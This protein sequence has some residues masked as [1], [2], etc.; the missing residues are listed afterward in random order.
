YTQVGR[1]QLRGTQRYRALNQARSDWLQGEYFRNGT[2][3]ARKVVVVGMGPAGATVL[4]NVS[5]D[6][7]PR[8]GFTVVGMGLRSHFEHMANF[9]TG[10]EVIRFAVPASM[11]D[12]RA[13]HPETYRAMFPA[14]RR[15]YLPYGTV[16]AVV[17]RIPAAMGPGGGNQGGFGQHGGRGYRLRRVPPGADVGA[18]PPHGEPRGAAQGEAAPVSP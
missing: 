3:P 18:V 5:G 14:S 15:T 17:E 9:E 16:M 6:L 2:Q 1:E 10:Q 4:A 13:L 8:R 11:A 7:N 12:D